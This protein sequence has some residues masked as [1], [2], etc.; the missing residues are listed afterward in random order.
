MNKR[1]LVVPAHVFFIL[2]TSSGKNFYHGTISEFFSDYA[3]ALSECNSLNRLHFNTLHEFR[4]GFCDHGYWL[5]KF[6]R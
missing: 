1:F 6:N 3:T 4:L 5:R 2:D